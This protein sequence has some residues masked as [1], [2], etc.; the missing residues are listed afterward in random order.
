MYTHVLNLNGGA[1]AVDVHY[2]SGGRKV[3]ETTYV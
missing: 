3:C 1:V 2:Q